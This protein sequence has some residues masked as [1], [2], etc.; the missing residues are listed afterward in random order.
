M[1]LFA[2]AIVTITVRSFDD[3]SRSVGSVM[4]SVVTEVGLGRVELGQGQEGQDGREKEDA[5][6]F[7]VSEHEMCCVS[8]K[9]K[10][11]F[12]LGGARGGRVGRG[13]TFPR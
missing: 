2:F 12:F 6:H 7:P 11:D 13:L 10:I 4:V 3:A 8:R 1:S 9:V 5:S